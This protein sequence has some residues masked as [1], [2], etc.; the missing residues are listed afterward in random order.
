MVFQETETRKTI[1]LSITI[2]RNKGWFGR[3]R[4]AKIMADNVEIG[5]VRSGESVCAN[6]PDDST[7]LHAKMDWGRSKPFSVANLRNE[8]TIYLN[9]WLT[10]N[11]LR[12]LGII[13]IPIALEEE[14]R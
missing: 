13:S 1:M 2:V 5:R 12:Y 14:P 11:P 6:V 4:V 8:Q 7:N 9:A 10:L 3:V